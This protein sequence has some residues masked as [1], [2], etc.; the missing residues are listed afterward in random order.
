M[1]LGRAASPQHVRVR[2]RTRTCSRD[3]SPDVN[4]DPRLGV[5]ACLDQLVVSSA[6][7]SQTTVYRKGGSRGRSV[8]LF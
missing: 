1:K 5:F 3:P 2:A 4:V 6:K 8:R 7:T